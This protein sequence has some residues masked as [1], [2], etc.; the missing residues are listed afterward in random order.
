MGAAAEVRIF[1][2]ERQD[3]SRRCCLWIRVMSLGQRLYATLKVV[4]S[5]V[6]Q[7]G[8]CRLHLLKSQFLQSSILEAF[9]ICVRICLARACVL[10]Y[11]EERKL[12][13]IEQGYASSGYMLR[14]GSSC[15]SG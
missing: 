15:S 13:Q 7:S 9:C 3:L 5:L 10:G 4:E 6:Q 11:L 14:T 12:W 1:K 2:V 8:C